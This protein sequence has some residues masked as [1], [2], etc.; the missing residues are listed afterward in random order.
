MNRCKCSLTGQALTVIFIVMLFSITQAALL[1]GIV[2]DT[3]TKAPV[4]SV[5]VKVKGT[6]IQAQTDAQGKFTLNVSTGIIQPEVFSSWDQ[7]L[8]G[9]PIVNAKVTIT[10]A[11]GS[12]LTSASGENLNAFLSRLPQGVYLIEV[13]SHG[14]KTRGQLLKMEKRYRTAWHATGNRSTGILGKVS[15]AV[16]LTYTH[17]YY[18][19]KEGTAN[20]GDTNVTMKLR[21]WFPGPYFH[22]GPTDTT[23]FTKMSGM[24]ISRSG[25]VLENVDIS[26]SVTFSSGVNNV[27]IRNFR[28]TSS[29]Y[30]GIDAGDQCTGCLF[31]DGEINGLNQMGDGFRGSYYTTRRLYIHN[32]GGDSYKANGN[33]VIEGCYITKIG[34]GSGAHGDGVQMMGSGNIRIIHNNFELNSG[35]LTA[36]VFPGGGGYIAGVYVLYNRLNG[37]AW[38]VYCNKDMQCICNQ[39]GHAGVYGTGLGDCGVNKWNVFEDTGLTP[40]K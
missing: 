7:S 23:K 2:N 10:G 22:T 36:C 25:T 1:K 6:S 40:T 27:T 13:Q 21:M 3:I 31:E 19:T 34:Q 16:T 33:N 28:I 24:T 4:E 35:S 15:A 26:G 29:G 9:F 8:D 37:G 5:L 32:M 11:N 39:F 12:S 38:T 30:W 20:T 18:N 14:Q 17:K